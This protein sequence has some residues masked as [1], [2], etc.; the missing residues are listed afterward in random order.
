METIGERLRIF[1]NYIGNLSKLATLINMSP[2]SLDAYLIGRSKPGTEILQ[3]LLKLGCNIN[4]L[5]SGEGE[6]LINNK[7]SP[8]QDIETIKAE[9]EEKISNLEKEISNLEKEIEKLNI[10]ISVYERVIQLISQ[11]KKGGQ[12]GESPKFMQVNL[13]TTSSPSKK[14]IKKQL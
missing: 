1:A 11:E 12:S 13:P 14:K 3:R 6:M 2:S 7:S 10:K 5:L 4:W 9:Y 8:G